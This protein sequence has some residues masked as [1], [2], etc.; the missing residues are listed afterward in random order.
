LTV[1]RFEGE[2]EGD[3]VL[4]QPVME[5]DSRKIESDTEW[6][7]EGSDLLSIKYTRGNTRQRK[8]DMTEDSLQKSS[9]EKALEKNDESSES[10]RNKASKMSNGEPISRAKSRPSPGVPYI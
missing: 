5:G 8:E 9:Q 7:S 4:K 1:L 2:V 3:R 6:L 10:K